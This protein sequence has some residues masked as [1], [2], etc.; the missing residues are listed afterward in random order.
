MIGAAVRA[1]GAAI[2]LV[3]AAV[4]MSGQRPPAIQSRDWKQLESDTLDVVGNASEK[5]LRRALDEIVA[6]RGALKKLLP[7]IDLS[8]PEPTAIIVFRDYASFSKFLPRDGRGKKQVGVGG[9]FSEEADRNLLVLPIF[10]SRE[11]TFRIAF[12]EYTHYIVARNLR[13]APLWLHEGLAEFYSTFEMDEGGTAL[14]GRSL[15]DRLTTLR[16][17]RMPPLARLLSGESGRRLFENDSD[18]SMFYA[19]SWLFVH[20]MTLSDNGSRQ[21][22]ILKYL[23]SLRSTKSAEAAAREAFGTTL[24]ALGNEMDRYARSFKLPAIRLAAVSKSAEPAVA[25]P[26]LE[27]DALELQGRLLVELG[28]LEEAEP[29]IARALAID[30]AHGDARVARARLLL[31]RDEDTDAIAILTE[32]VRER[33]G[34]FYSQYTLGS[35]LQKAERYDEALKAYERALNISRRSA[36]AWFGAAMAAMGAG[37]NEQS[38]SA[39][40]QV[41]ELES[42][43]KWHY[44]RA[45]GALKMHRDAAVIIEARTFIDSAGISDEAAPYAAFAGAIAARRIGRSRDADELLARILPALRPKSWQLTVSQYLQ[46]SLSDTQFIDKAKDNGQRTEAHA[47]VALACLQAGRTDEGKRHLLWVKEKG[48]RNYTEYSIAVAELKRLG[49]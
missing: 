42:S 41:Q 40:A 12:H 5:D 32:V 19:Q 24:D 27:I 47:Y 2:S 31:E 3:A 9:Y 39:M 44:S 30:P 22:Q 35:A 8:A 48:D 10:A 36:S 14:I 25:T 1:A 43:P 17:S 13:D 21:R 33:P 20:F 38:D 46:G 34:D 28:G 18:T 11:E 26:M 6:F 4:A 16:A 37:Q 15:P 29:L 45:L 7:R 49:K 23:D